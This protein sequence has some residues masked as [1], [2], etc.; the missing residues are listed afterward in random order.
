MAFAIIVA[1]QLSQGMY[2]VD[3]PTDALEWQVRQV[4]GPWN[5]APPARPPGG[6]PPPNGMGPASNG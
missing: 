5:G 3:A 6:V 1:A 2:V 4:S